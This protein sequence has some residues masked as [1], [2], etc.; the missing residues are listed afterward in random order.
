MEEKQIV[1][2]KKRSMQYL[3]A[4]ELEYRLR[5]KEDFYTYLDEHRK[6]PAR[7]CPFCIH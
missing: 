3:D 2:S 5:S 7:G 6:C 4:R 1:E